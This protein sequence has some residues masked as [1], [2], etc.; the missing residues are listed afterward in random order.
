M[1]LRGGR[2]CCSL[3]C[4]CRCR[5]FACSKHQPRALPSV[6]VTRTSGTRCGRRGVGAHFCEARAEERFRLARAGAAGLARGEAREAGRLSRCSTCA[7]PGDTGDQ[8]RIERFAVRARPFVVV[9]A[10]DVQW[11]AGG[12]LRRAASPERR[13]LVPH[14]DELEAGLDPQ[15]F[16]RIHRHLVRST[17]SASVRPHATTRAA[18]DRDAPMS[19]RIGKCWWSGGGALE[20]D[21]ATNATGGVLTEPPSSEVYSALLGLRMPLSLRPA[22]R[23]TPRLPSA[24]L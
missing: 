22:S 20:S 13:A 2:T 10:A 14:D 23:R 7:R 19:R 18:R 17:A 1:L 5:R 9:L 8:R 12:Q 3:M 24:S 15:R 21:S 4:R 6:F 16:A 11:I